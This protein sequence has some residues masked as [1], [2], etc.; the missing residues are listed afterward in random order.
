MKNLTQANLLGNLTI[1]NIPIKKR[2]PSSQAKPSTD[3]PPLNS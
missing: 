2:E 1:R 3:R